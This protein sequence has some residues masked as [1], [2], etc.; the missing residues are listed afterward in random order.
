M[1]EYRVA[2]EWIGVPV[3]ALPAIH[4]IEANL[5]RTRNV[6]GAFML[7][8]G[9]DGTTMFDKNIRDYE[10]IV[11]KRLNISPVPKVSRDFWF[12][13]TCAAYELREKRRG[14]GWGRDVLAD[15]MW[16]YNGR[17]KSH[18]TWRDSAYVWND[19]KRG[20]RI[21][22]CGRTKTYLCERPGAIVIYDEIKRRL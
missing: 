6:G 9:G 4:Y 21:W 12:A 5:E 11:A 14:R 8:R 15:A 18:R 17:P 13:A 10:R 16:G 22:V 7:D 2:A 1:D 20:R 3:L 19:P